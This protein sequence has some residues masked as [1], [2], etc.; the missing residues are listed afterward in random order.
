MAYS[1]VLRAMQQYGSYFNYGNYESTDPIHFMQ[2]P[3]GV[4]Y[5]GVFAYG[6]MYANF[7]FD[8]QAADQENGRAGNTLGYVGDS[9]TMKGTFQPAR[10][11][12]GNFIQ[13]IPALQTEHQFFADHKFTF[14]TDNPASIY[15][16]PY[17]MN[18]LTEMNDHSTNLIGT[19]GL[20]NGGLEKRHIFNGMNDGHYDMQGI[21]TP[22]WGVT[23]PGNLNNVMSYSANIVS[24]IKADTVTLSLLEDSF[25]IAFATN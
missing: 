8:W 22:K 25:S 6:D 14:G 11:L 15:Y 4:G 10:E 16:N 21:E 9:V 13:D 3:I 23:N 18:P 7:K 5:V 20:S 1:D 19:G 24:Y 17:N 12:S 2:L